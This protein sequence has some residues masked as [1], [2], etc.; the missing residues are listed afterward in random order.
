[1]CFSPFSATLGPTYNEQI[2]VQK[3][4]RCM[5]ML[6]VTEL[7]NIAVHDFDAKKSTRFR[8]VLVVTELFNIAVHDFDAKKSTH[9]RRVLVVTE[10]VISGTKC[11]SFFGPWTPPPPHTH[12]HET[13]I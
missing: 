4:A 5:R 12:T 3:T 13:G 7:F 10:L 11:T 6:A 1:M 8:R 2:D 9:C